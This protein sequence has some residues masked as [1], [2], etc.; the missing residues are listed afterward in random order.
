MQ[1]LVILR[2][3][4]DAAEDAVA[5][6]RR[7]EVAKVWDYF[8]ADV[9]RSI[10]FIPGPGATFVLETPD[11]ATAQAHVDALPMIR[12]GLADAEVLPMAPFTGFAALF[13]G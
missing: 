7:A 4:P 3:R 1:H 5:A 2:M 12:E 8:A 6:Q 10:H 13:A 9:L 11:L